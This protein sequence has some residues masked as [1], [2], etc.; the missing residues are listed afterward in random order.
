[1][2]EPQSELFDAGFQCVRYFEHRGKV[3]VGAEDSAI[4]IFNIG[5]WGNISDRFPI[6]TR[7]PSRK[8][9]GNCIDCMELI[10]DDQ[11]DKYVVLGCSDG[12]L[13]LL[14][15]LPNKVI[16]QVNDHVTS[17][18]SLCVNNNTKV[19]A[20]TDGP[21]IYLHQFERQK[22]TDKSSSSS[23]SSSMTTNSSSG[24]FSDL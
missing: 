17:I 5:Q 18:E 14:N 8:S 24:F 3:L 6:K 19:I 13:R 21:T 20:S 12:H 23:S 2:E 1:M 15:V 10:S 16:A 4:N 11:E 7:L 9:A 22:E